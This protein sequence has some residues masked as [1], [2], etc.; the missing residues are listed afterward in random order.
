[1]SNRHPWHIAGMLGVE[2]ALILAAAAIAAVTP[3]SAGSGAAYFIIALLAVAMGMR[4]ANV[5]RLGV[6]DLTTT[7]L[8]MTLTGL[9]AE[10]RLGGGSGQGSIRR[11]TS[12]LSLLAGALTG[13]LLAR[14]SVAI[15]L[16]VAAGLALATLLLYVPV[17]MQLGRAQ[18]LIASPGSSN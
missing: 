15:P 8:T 5:R 7:V 2:A 12:V 6:P 14:I 18:A 9:A 3:V 1:M 10:S 17:A 16:A 13:A 11:A 4:N